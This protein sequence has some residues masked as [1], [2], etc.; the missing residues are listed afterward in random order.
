M[1]F[2]TA[3]L[4]NSHLPRQ[5]LDG[6]LQMGVHLWR[7]WHGVEGA[8]GGPLRFCPPPTLSLPSRAHA[9]GRGARLWGGCGGWWRSQQLL[10]LMTMRVVGLIMMIVLLQL[11]LLP[12]HL[13]KQNKTKQ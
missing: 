12:L 8:V 7:F 10:L 13:K 5:T 3:K 4:K 1:Y 2:Y 9:E 11:L 6:S